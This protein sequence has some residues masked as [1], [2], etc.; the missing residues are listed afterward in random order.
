MALLC[1]LCQLLPG[2][3][4]LGGILV[5]WLTQKDTKPFVDRC[6]K[7]V[8]NWMITSVIVAVCCIPL[9]FLG[10]CCFLLGIP[11]LLIVIGL[12]TYGIVTGILGAVKA[13][14]GQFF[15]HPICLRLVK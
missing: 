11:A 6:G 4:G 3:L 8:L 2:L 15:K 9:V 5:L 10:V 12:Y 14:N 13:S 1:Y 7:E